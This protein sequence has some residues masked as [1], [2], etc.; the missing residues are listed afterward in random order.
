MGRLQEI[1]CIF[2][3]LSLIKCA[4]AHF[5]LEIV[6]IVISILRIVIA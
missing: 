5:E 6:I 3:Y 2:N 4:L 1:T